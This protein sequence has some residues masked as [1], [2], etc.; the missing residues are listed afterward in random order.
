MT[1]IMIEDIGIS[2]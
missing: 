2:K 1:K